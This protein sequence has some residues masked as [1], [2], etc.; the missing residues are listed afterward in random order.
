MYTSQLDTHSLHQHTS[1]QLPKVVIV[2]RLEEVEPPHVA[3]VGG[4]LLRVALAQHL[5]GGGALGVADFL[6]S[7]LESV[8]VK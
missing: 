7:L 6:V 8:F 4:Q 1:E 5:D 2:G 3:E